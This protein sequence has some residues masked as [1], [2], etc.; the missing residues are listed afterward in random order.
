MLTKY[1]PALHSNQGRNFE[2]AMLQQT[3]DAFGIRKSRTTAYHPESDGMVER[4]N[5]TLLQLL[6][7]YTETHDEWEHYQQFVLFAYRTAVHSSTGV[8]PFAL[9]FGHSPVKNPFLTQTAYDAVSYQSQLQTKLAQLSDF[10]ETH[11][12]QA[13]HKQ[14]TAYD[15]RTQQ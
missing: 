12:A 15:Q 9:M 14:K 1:A 7:A 11:L 10:V 5:R 2:S 6:C 4:F 3:L 13:A 8:S